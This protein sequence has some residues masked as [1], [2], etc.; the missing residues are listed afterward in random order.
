MKRII[1]GFLLALVTQ[2]CLG[3][4]PHFSQFF[5]SPLYLSPSLSGAANGTRLISNY[6]NQWPSIENAFTNYAFSIDHFFKNYHSGVGILALREEEGGVYGTN[7]I[8]GTY[9]YNI[10]IDKNWSINPGILFSYNNNFLDWNKLEFGDQ[11]YRNSNS[12][13]EYMQSES[14]NYFDF[15][16]SLLVYS[17]QYWFGFTSAHLMNLNKDIALEEEGYPGLK[18]SV[19]GGAKLY[20]RSSS[21]MRSDKSYTLAF[22]YKQQNNLHQLDLGAHYE[23]DYLRVGLWLRGSKNYLDKIGVDA[24]VFLVGFSFENIKFN[25]SYDVSTSRLMTLSGGA[26]EISL[27]YTILNENHRKSNRRKMVPCPEF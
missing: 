5:S 12:T 4:D 6:R 25:Y 17:E 23:R 2:A 18:T 14:Y 21:I 1:Y 20:H 24:T 22:I 9:T 3:Q 15:N 8:G 7:S 13:I 16:G 11:I 19:Y 26:H 10:Q 27:M